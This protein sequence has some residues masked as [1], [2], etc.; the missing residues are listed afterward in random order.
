MAKQCVLINIK[1]N[2]AIATNDLTKGDKV[3][4]L[5]GQGA[6]EVILNNDIPFGH[7]FAIRQIDQGQQVIKYGE[8]IGIATKGIMIGD[9]VHVDNVDSE[10]G[11]GD[12]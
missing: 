9:H 8:P 1:D 4:V 11:R 7:K 5:S 6:I 3:R 10:R 2:V 12:L